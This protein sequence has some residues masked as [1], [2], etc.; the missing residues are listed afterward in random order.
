MCLSRESLNY[1]MR[2]MTCCVN[3]FLLWPI[4]KQTE[5]CQRTVALNLQRDLKIF[6]N[7]IGPSMVSL[8]KKTQS[9]LFLYRTLHVTWQIRKIN[10]KYRCL[11]VLEK[12]F[13]FCCASVESIHYDNTVSSDDILG[14][15]SKIYPHQFSLT[16][17]VLFQ[18]YT[19]IS[20][21]T[22]TL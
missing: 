18:P 8:G 17:T 15:L 14:T 2:R 20:D 6:T 7:F 22:L 9:N 1:S 12:K 16:F 3:K 10:C 11:L 19:F 4:I 13:I 5:K 21:L